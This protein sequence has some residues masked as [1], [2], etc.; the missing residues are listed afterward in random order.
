MNDSLISVIVAIYNV[1][2][3]LDKCVL[4]I[5]NQT[6]KNLEIIL[7]DDGSTD[8]SPDKCESWKKKDNRIVVIHQKN[9][10]A[11]FARNKG[12]NI[13][14]GRFISFVDA[15]DYI[16]PFMYESMIAE[17]EN[18]SS[19]IVVCGVNWVNENG[20][21][22]KNE[23]SSKVFSN[24]VSAMRD[25]LNNDCLKEQVWDKLYRYDMIKN[26]L[27]CEGKKIDDVFWTYKAIS[28]AN[29]ITVIKSSYYNYVQRLGSVMGGGYK[30]YWVQA[31]EA[32]QIRCEFIRTNMFE[33]YNES[34]IKY[35]E[36]C[37][38]HL[39]KA[40]KHKQ[41]KIIINSIKS[42]ITYGKQNVSYYSDVPFK[43][44]I[45]LRLFTV[46]PEFVSITRNVLKKGL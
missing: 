22:I 3:Y 18:T 37:M 29:K 7:I 39:Q 14:N 8:K 13:A 19:D 11:P 27:F 30:S 26:I 10:G 33:L 32:Y 5:V 21:I 43:R 4:S 16:S 34:V 38:F 36:V 9:Q 45:W 17:M 15:D 42:K 31:L 6:Y 40:I 12:L 20:V 46:F 35:L 41:N 25:L 44:K 2:C 1:E 24:K 28:K 23:S